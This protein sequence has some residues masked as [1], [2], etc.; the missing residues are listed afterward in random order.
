MVQDWCLALEDGQATIATLPN[1][2]SFNMAN[3]APILHLMCKAATQ[4]AA[5][6]AVVLNSLTSA[7]LLW[8]LPQFN[9]GLHSPTSP[10]TPTPQTPGWCQVRDM[11]SRSSLPIPSPSKLLHFLQFSKTHLSV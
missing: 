7:I 5:P 11:D 4:P 8:T 2:E 1:I 3:K 9:S 6:T 10:I